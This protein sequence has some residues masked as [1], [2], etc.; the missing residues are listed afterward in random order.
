VKDHHYRS[1]HETIG[2]FIIRMY[3]P[4]QSFIYFKL[5]PENIDVTIELIKK[6]THQFAPDFPFRFAFLDD[7]YNRLYEVENRM[8]KIYQAFAFLAIVISCLGLLGLASYTIEQRTKEIGIRKV[9]GASIAG[10]IQLLTNEFIRWIIV[11]NIIA[12]PIAYF[13]MKAWL[14]NFAYRIDINFWIFLLAG[15]LALVIALLTVSL[16][17][18]RAA[19]AK[20]VESLRYE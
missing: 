15:S 20:P 5:K 19:T 8:E 17:A 7:T 10:I 9:L 6:V 2:P 18:F 13:A 3:K 14:Q 12:L 11:A 4:Y 1:L 16:Q